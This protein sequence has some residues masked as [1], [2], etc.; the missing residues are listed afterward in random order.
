MGPV[1][2]VVLELA[3][4]SAAGAEL[5]PSSAVLVTVT[6]RDSLVVGGASVEAVVV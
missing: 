3:W 5:T 4:V 6:D 2:F 1:L